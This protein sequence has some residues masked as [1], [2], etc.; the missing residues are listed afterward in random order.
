MAEKRLVTAVEWKLHNRKTIQ[1]GT[2]LMLEFWNPHTFIRDHEGSDECLKGVTRLPAT[3]STR[4]PGT[5]FFGHQTPV[6]KWGYSHERDTYYVWTREN[7]DVIFALPMNLRFSHPK[8]KQTPHVVMKLISKC[9][10]RVPADQFPK[11]Q[12]KMMLPYA[13]SEPQ[14]A[15]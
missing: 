8:W 12:R 14:I 6:S 13:A 11:R 3:K 5:T 9:T 15:S 10:S 7:T 2:E 4:F 1:G